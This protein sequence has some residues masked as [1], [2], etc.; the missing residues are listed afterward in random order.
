MSGNEDV[1]GFDAGRCAGDHRRTLRARRRERERYSVVEKTTRAQR[2]RRRSACDIVIIVCAALLKCP[3]A[4]LIRPKAFVRNAAREYGLLKA[5]ARDADDALKGMP[6]D[7]WRPLL[8]RAF[9]F[10]EQMKHCAD[11]T[12]AEHHGRPDRWLAFA[13]PGR[14]T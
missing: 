2:V 3:C 11:E 1:D 8:D 13:R 4:R 9:S 14:S 12:V 7:R 6:G 5:R 10:L